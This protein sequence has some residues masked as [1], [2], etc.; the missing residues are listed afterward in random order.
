MRNLRHLAAAV[1]VAAAAGT[2]APGPTSPAQAATCADSGGVSV[3]VDFKGL[4]GGL[5]SVCDSSG[6][7][8]KAAALFDAQRVRADLRPADAGLRVPGP[9]APGERPVHQ[10]LTRQRL[11]GA[12]VVQ[13][14]DR[15]VVLL[16]PGRRLADDPR[17]RLGG[18][19][20]GRGRRPVG[21]GRRPAQTVCTQPYPV[22]DHVSEPHPGDH[23]GAQPGAQP[24]PSTKPTPTPT[25]K[26]TPAPVSPT[27]TPVPTEAPAPTATPTET[28]S[29]TETP[30]PAPTASRP[31]PPST[32]ADETVSTSAP[33]AADDSGLPPWVPVAVI[34]ALFAGAAGV[35][36]VRRQRT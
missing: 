19:R 3:V 32:T 17:G 25:V 30:S 23:P 6:G 9:G 29:P 28:R 4:G 12:V 13:R 27:P 22:P 8:Q 18:L 5:Q 20:L 24:A 21:A 36:V 34:L 1:L 14:H 31:S 15:Q 16:H 35:V 26:P 10:H 2:L 33:V 11:L 7:G